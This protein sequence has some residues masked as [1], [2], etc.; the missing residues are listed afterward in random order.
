M[1]YEYNGNLTYEERISLVSREITKYYPFI[2]KSESI[3]IA[4]LEPPINNEINDVIKFRR[5]YTILFVK[6]DNNVFDIVLKDILKLDKNN[7]IIKNGIIK[8][9]E[10]KNNNVFPDV[11][12]IF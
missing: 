9:L 10:Y 11:K 4:T 12:D 5:L 1:K 7:E 3:L 8:L 6:R 2:T